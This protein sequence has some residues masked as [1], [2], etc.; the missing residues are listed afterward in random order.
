MVSTFNTEFFCVEELDEL[1]STIEYPGE[2]LDPHAKRFHGKELACG[3][4]VDKEV[5]INGYLYGMVNDYHV[6]LDIFPSL[7]F[8][9]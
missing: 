2:D 3:D 9:S 8:L 6:F 5:L 4:P 7:P 1:G